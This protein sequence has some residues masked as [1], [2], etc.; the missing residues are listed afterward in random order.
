MKKN[1]GSKE[2]LKRNIKILD[3]VNCILV[4][5]IA[6]LGEFPC[7]FDNSLINSFHSLNNWTDFG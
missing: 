4:G 6:T 7:L 1:N 5:I 2:V 3:Y